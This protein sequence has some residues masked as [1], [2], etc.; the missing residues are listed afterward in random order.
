[1]SDRLERV[2]G[3]DAALGPPEQL[4]PFPFFECELFKKWGAAT[5]GGGG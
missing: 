2:W 1:M 5:L 3:I 4:L